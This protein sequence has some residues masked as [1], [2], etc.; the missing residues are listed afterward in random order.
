M[1]MMMLYMSSKAPPPCLVN[2]RYLHQE[3]CDEKGIHN[4]SRNIIQEIYRRA[5]CEL[6]WRSFRSS[7]TASSRFSFYFHE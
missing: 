1:M 5:A 3:G 7:R 2:F 6:P 4:H